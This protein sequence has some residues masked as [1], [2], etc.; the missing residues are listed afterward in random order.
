VDWVDTHGFTEFEGEMAW[1]RLA[2][3]GSWEPTSYQ[4]F[5]NRLER[6]LTIRATIRLE[7]VVP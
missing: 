1:M 6:D 4:P 5:I 7:A 2:G 3:N